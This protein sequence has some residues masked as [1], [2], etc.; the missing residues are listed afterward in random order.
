MIAPVSKIWSC[1]AGETLIRGAWVHLKQDANYFM[2]AFL[3]DD[4]KKIDGI[5]L[6]DA[7]QG[8]QVDIAVVGYAKVSYERIPA[9]RP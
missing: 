1:Y 3:T 6:V 4:P 7:P 2:V 5:A 9:I 8:N